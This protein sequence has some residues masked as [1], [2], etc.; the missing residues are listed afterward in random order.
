MHVVILHEPEAAHSGPGT[1]LTLPAG[2]C[3]L[4]EVG[5]RNWYVCEF[6]IPV[7]SYTMSKNNSII[8]LDFPIL[9]WKQ[10]E[11]AVKQVPMQRH[12]LRNVKGSV[13]TVPHRLD[14]CGLS[15]LLLKVIA[16]LQLLRGTCSSPGF[17]PYSRVILLPS[18][19]WEMWIP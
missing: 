2:V 13:C 15:R 12:N 3:K 7:L 5:L 16:H 10:K 18:D 14:G 8:S 9:I 17:H 19:R 1:V 4:T 6:F 11:H